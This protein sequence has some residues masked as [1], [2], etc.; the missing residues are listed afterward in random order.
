AFNNQKI[1][2]FDE[3]Q[4]KASLCISGESEKIRGLA[5][6]GKTGI[7]AIKAARLHYKYPDKKIL[8]TFSTH[9]LYN[10]IINLTRKYYYKLTGKYPDQNLSI[11]HAW[12]GKTVGTGVYY[13]ACVRNGLKP[14]TLRDATNAKTSRLALDY[15]CTKILDEELREEYDLILLDE[16]QDMPKSFF[17]LLE[18]ISIKPA[19]IIYAYDELQNINNV[20]LEEPEDLFGKKTNGEPRIK[21]NAENDHILKRTYRNHKKVLLTAIGFGFGFYSNNGL[22]QLL[23]DKSTWEA[24]GFTI[25]ATLFENTQVTVSRSKYNSPNDLDEV[26]KEQPIVNFQRQENSD[27]EI[28]YVVK[29]IKRLI[30]VEKVRPEDIMIISLSKESTEFLKQVQYSLYDEKIS[31]TIPGVVDGARDFVMEGSITLTTVRKAK[32]NEVPIVFVMNL[33][34]TYNGTS[35]LLRRNLRYQAFISMTRAKA[36][37]YLTG[38]CKNSNLLEEEFNLIHDDL[39][40][41]N[42]LKFNYPSEEEIKDIERINILVN[43]KDKSEA[44][45]SGV[46]FINKLIEEGDLELLTA[47]LDDDAKQKLINE[48][49]RR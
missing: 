5:G 2:I 38:S 7:L 37:L 43:D 49:N 6:T 40:K 29:E 39:I 46:S 26:Y 30:E 25:Q 4:L 11:M 22:V 12:G 13:N 28:K 27:E 33:Q 34:T 20:T 14:L 24:L 17:Q 15:V 42:S 3:E 23:N 45:G 36:W 47:M 18:K 21:I 41:F 10:Q 1:N 35:Q 16:A 31:T 9:S 8:V 19:N 44:M 48:L 32:G